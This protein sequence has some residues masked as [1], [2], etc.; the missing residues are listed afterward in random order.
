M[1]LT[2]NARQQ[3]YYDELHIFAQS[4]GWKLLS[5]EYINAD[6][7]LEVECPRGHYRKM[8]L[9]NFKYAKVCSLCPTPKCIKA[10]QKFREKVATFGG[11]AGIYKNSYTDVS[12]VCI[13]G[14]HFE[15]RPASFVPGDGFFAESVNKL[16][17][18]ITL[19]NFIPKLRLEVEQF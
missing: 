4:K 6:T 5:K 3:K 9:S 7:Y 19:E 18:K 10:E 14:H 1:Q 15:L 2:M 8:K 13:E 12:C 16:Q 11:Q 17:W